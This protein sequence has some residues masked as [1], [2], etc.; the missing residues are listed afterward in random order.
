MEGLYWVIDFLPEQVPDGSPGQ[1]FAVE[2]FYEAEP[3]RTALRGRF[4]E[5][6]LRLNCYFDLQACEPEEEQWRLNPPPQTLYAWITEN[7]RDLRLRLPGHDTMI[8]LDRND[9]C[10]TVYQPSE[11]L[12]HL[13][14]RLVAASGL[15]LWQPP[16]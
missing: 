6:I 13:L 4:A 1:F 8:V 2:R 11:G 10:M 16:Q 5:I 3:C 7:R 14:D 9:T 15:F 12:L